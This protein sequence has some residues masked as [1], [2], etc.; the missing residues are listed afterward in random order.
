MNFEKPL[1]PGAPGNDAPLATGRSLVADAAAHCPL[2]SLARNDPD[3]R[4]D[5]AYW[6][7]S[8]WLPTAYMTVKAVADARLLLADAC[9]H[10]DAVHGGVSPRKTARSTLVRVTHAPG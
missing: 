5:G 8:V 9:P 3:F 10:G 7:G 2:P 4:P 6:R 1:W